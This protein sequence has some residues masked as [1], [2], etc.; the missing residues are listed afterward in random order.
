MTKLYT[1]VGLRLNGETLANDVQEGIEALKKDIEFWQ[2]GIA[3]NSDFKTI[4][5]NRVKKFQHVVTV[6]K[7]IQSRLHDNHLRIEDD[8]G[9]CQ[10]LVDG[11][12]SQ[13]GFMII[14]DIYL[15]PE[16]NSKLLQQWGNLI[17]KFAKEL[18]GYSGIM[19]TLVSED[20]IAKLQ[21]L[22]FVV[23]SKFYNKRSTN[24]VQV[25]FKAL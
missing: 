1:D 18:C 9:I 20:K 8:D 12:P 13:C 23:V 22:G 4:Y 17:D 10:C 2:D 11:M 16:V 7:E 6:L 24:N 25:L 21:S 15:S 14:H 5:G 3:K 19:A